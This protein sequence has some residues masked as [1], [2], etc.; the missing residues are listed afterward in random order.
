MCLFVVSVLR[1]SS[2][3]SISFRY[4]VSV[5]FLT[6]AIPAACARARGRGFRTL[7]DD[8]TVTS[9]NCRHQ[10]PD[11]NMAAAAAAAAADHL[12]ADRAC[13]IHRLARLFPVNGTTPDRSTADISRSSR[14][15][16]TGHSL[17][18]HWLLS[19]CS[20]CGIMTTSP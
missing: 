18:Q 10:S 17:Y 6:R 19:M 20:A 12:S 1:D 4:I 3:Q 14:Y 8:V 16:A 11:A 13:V 9:S 5:F 15:T 7:N 2:L